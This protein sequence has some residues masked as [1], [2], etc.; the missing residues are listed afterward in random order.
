LYGLLPFPEDL[1][2]VVIANVFKASFDEFA[3]S[4]FR[5]CHSCNVLIIFE[6]NE[7][8]KTKIG[9]EGLKELKEIVDSSKNYG[10]TDR[11]VVD[12]SLARGLD[13]YTGPIFEVIDTSGKN[14]GSL[15]G[16]GRYDKLIEIFGG[17]PT[18]ATG[19]S[20]GIERIIEVMREEKMFDFPRTKIKVFV[21]NVNE[22]VKDDT[23][24]VTQELRKNGIPCQSDLMNRGL[25][26]QL[27]FADSLGIPY[28]IIIGPKELRKKV[29][30]LRDMKKKIESE[31]K[32]EELKKKLS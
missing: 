3:H 11:I 7:L 25:G 13:Y 12:F 31:V 1:A 24:K 17:R 27:E 28:V 4:L 19:I 23:I 10:F 14:I 6:V 18:P 29:V 5:T 21:A 9:L 22:E 32:I 2:S 15:S 30:K 26:K 16:G 8:S 20:L